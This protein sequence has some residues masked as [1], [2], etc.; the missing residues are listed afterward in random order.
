[1]RGL[2]VGLLAK[3]RRAKGEL[4]DQHAGPPKWSH[5]HTTTIPRT[6]PAAVESCA[7]TPGRIKAGGREVGQA[8]RRV[9]GSGPDLAGPPGRRSADPDLDP[10]P[11]PGCDR[12]D[13]RPSG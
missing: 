3:G 9:P 13:W 5:A 4:R 8:S 10:A 12:R 1:M 7:S 6:P 2:L 11:L